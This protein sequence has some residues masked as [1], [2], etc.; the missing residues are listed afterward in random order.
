MQNRLNTR[1]ELV[2]EIFSFLVNSVV[3]INC[4]TDLNQNQIDSYKGAK[5]RSEIRSD[6]LLDLDLN[7]KDQ[8]V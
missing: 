3:K 4:K 1:K 2:A 8:T 6:H 7:R 5:I